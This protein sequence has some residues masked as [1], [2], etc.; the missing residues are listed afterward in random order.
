MP[1]KQL[2]TIIASTANLVSQKGG[3]GDFVTTTGYHASFPGIGGA[4]YQYHKTGRSTHTQDTVLYWNGPGSDDYW[5]LVLEGNDLDLTKAG[6]VPNDSASATQ[7]NT[8]FA[9][10]TGTALK[11]F[12]LPSDKA[13]ATYY[14]FNSGLTLPQ[15]KILEGDSYLNVRLRPA[16]QITAGVNF[17]TFN[18]DCVVRNLS[19]QGVPATGSTSTGNGLFSANGSSKWVL[20]NVRS[21]QW[22]AGFHL[23]H[24]WIGRL[25]N[26]LGG[27]CSTAALLATGGEGLEVNAIIVDGGEYA[28]SPACIRL[29]SNCNSIKINSTIEGATAAGDAYGIWL[30]GAYIYNNFVCEDCY[31]EHNKTHHIYADS[32]CVLMGGKIAGNGF[33]AETEDE[34]IYISRW[35]GTTLGTNIFRY[36]PSVASR[37]LYLSSQCLNGTVYK[38]SRGNQVDGEYADLVD[39]GKNYKV[40]VDGVI[41]LGSDNFKINS[42]YNTID[43]D[44]DTSVITG[45]GRSGFPN[46]IGHTGKPAGADFMPTDWADDSGYIDGAAIVTTISGGYDNVVNAIGS[47]ICGGGHNFVKYNTGGHGFIGGGSYNLINAERSAIV[48]GRR[49]TI[50]GGTGALFSFIGCGD[51]NNVIDTDYGIIIGGLSNTVDS[52]QF[53]VIVGGNENEV[54]NIASVCVGGYNNVVSGAYSSSLGGRDHIVGAYGSAAIGENVEIPVGRDFSFITGVDGIVRSEASVTQS[55][56]K[57]VQDGDSQA[58]TV[59]MAARTTNNTLTN[60]S[61]GSG[62]SFIELDDTKI[63]TGTMKVLLTAV[64]DG[65]ADANNDSNYQQVSYSGEIGFYWDGTNGFLFTGSSQTSVGASPTINLTELAA[66]TNNHFVPGA[67]PHIAINTGAIRIK[68]TG[69]A[70]TTINW[71]AKIDYVMTMIS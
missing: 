33:Y 9:A 69:I 37:H 23:R 58:S 12:R 49:N 60:M 32:N 52:T 1:I 26:C 57:L 40:G 45:P 30:T 14:F 70:S 39:L 15:G 65:S 62:S 22:G 50:T 43:I 41:P 54:S 47:T 5:E 34:A 71:V 66:N 55:R 21:I 17:F 2:S 28:S 51:D 46:R 20:E 16:T 61:C 19:F 42:L 6:I 18:S 59:V 48:A 64:R 35:D 44:V 11:R 3:D 27:T 36:D 24:T 53:A 10:A 38:Q 68:V 25:Q 31:F 8:K 29:E 63:S 13:A 67:A 4:T 56:R 7:N